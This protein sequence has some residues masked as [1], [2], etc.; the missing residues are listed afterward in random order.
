MGR[1]SKFS[2]RQIIGFKRRLE[3]ER[4][5]DQVDESHPEFIST[6]LDRWASGTEHPVSRI[7]RKILIC[8]HHHNK[9]EY[10]R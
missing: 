10:G 7:N 5:R 9:G 3:D 4:A 2:D 6:A 8:N 1:K